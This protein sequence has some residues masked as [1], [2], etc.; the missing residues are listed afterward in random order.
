MAMSKIDISV[1]IPVKNGQ[2]YLDS[3]LKNIFSQKVNGE[4]EVIAVESGSQDKTIDIVRRYAVR[5]YQ[6]EEDCFNHG[7]TRN[8]GIS[9]SQGE[10]IILMSSD[11]IPYNDCWMDKLVENLKRDEQVA[12]VYSRQLAHKDAQPLTQM[13]VSRFFTASCERRESQNINRD[14][15][16]KLS[17]SDKHRFCNFDNVSSCIRRSVWEKFPFPK[18]DF[19]EDLE[20]SK[21]VLESGYKIVYEPK[22]VVYHSHDF[23]VLG[24]YKKTLINYNKLYS[25][26]GLSAV[27]NIYKLFRNFII[28]TFRDIYQLCRGEKNPK[29]VLANIYLVPLYSFSTALGQYRSTKG[30]D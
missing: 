6:I 11:A 1:V 12:G 21:R 14:D 13:R 26:F 3:V 17:P 30:F 5:L 28:Y 20:W 27:D 19:A 16:L 18:T 22:S 7:L 15:Y 23:S 24:W 25:L 8:Y 4:F 9:K 29:I 10:Y 2:R